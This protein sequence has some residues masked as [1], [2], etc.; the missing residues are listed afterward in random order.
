LRRTANWVATT[1]TCAGRPRPEAPSG[2]RKS[3]IQEVPQVSGAF[4]RDV[5]RRNVHV[6]PQS[7]QSIRLIVGVA[8]ALDHQV[9]VVSDLF[10]GGDD[11]GKIDVPGAEQTAVV[12]AQVQMPEPLAQRADRGG[13]AL[14]FDVA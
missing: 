11:A 5:F 9:A 8:K 2:W 6:G 1:S 12:L 4:E 14:L 13:N 7:A 3:L 10:E